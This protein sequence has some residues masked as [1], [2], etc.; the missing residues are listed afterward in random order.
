MS[1][2]Q[3]AEEAVKKRDTRLKKNRCVC[4]S[5][6]FVFQYCHFWKQFCADM[7]ILLQYYLMTKE[8]HGPQHPV[9]VFHDLYTI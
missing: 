2:E 5:A 9:S 6:P 8:C 1:T 4:A 3:L 7:F